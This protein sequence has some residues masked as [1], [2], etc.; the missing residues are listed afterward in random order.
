M[1]R[2]CVIAACALLFRGIMSET[3]ILEAL[4][5]G[6]VPIASRINYDPGCALISP[7]T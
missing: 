7:S 1:L 4:N 5:G 6:N 3:D 2:G